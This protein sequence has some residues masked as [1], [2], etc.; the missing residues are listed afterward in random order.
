MRSVVAIQQLE[1]GIADGG[2]IDS[3]KTPE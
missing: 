2:G 3:K 1:A